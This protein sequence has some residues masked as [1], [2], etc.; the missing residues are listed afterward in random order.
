MMHLQNGETRTPILNMLKIL[1][2]E[3]D[4]GILDQSLEHKEMI[5]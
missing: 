3:V 2:K 1:Q 4:A 5:S